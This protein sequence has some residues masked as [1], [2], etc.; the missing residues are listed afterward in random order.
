M[1]EC[2]V[3]G[4]KCKHYGKG[5]CNKHYQQ[6]RKNG[7]ITLNTNQDF[8]IVI[9]KAKHYELILTNIK[10]KEVGRAKVDKEDL[11]KVKAVGRWTLQNFGYV[12][13][14]TN[15]IMMHR[16][17]MDAKKNEYIDHI[18]TGRVH[19]SDNRKKNLRKATGEQNRQNI[20]LRKN[21]T[22]GYKGVV[23]SAATNKWIA[24]IFKGK[25]RIHLGVFS[26]AELAYEAY[27]KAAKKL[28][29]EFFNPGKT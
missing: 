14:K 2:L 6:I 17:V 13:N 15:N 18:K 9:N 23:W 25:N 12:Y 22:S 11:P 4:C 7:Y 29:G 16:L 24:Q 5:Y 8:N 21:N 28:H 20:G 27:C 26:T 19:K 1:G 10:G 3:T